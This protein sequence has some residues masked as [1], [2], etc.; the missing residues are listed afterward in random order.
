[1]A[2]QLTDIVIV[3]IYLL[4]LIGIGIIASRKIKNCEDFICA[5]HSLGFWLFTILMIGTVCSGMS[6]LGV[7]GFGYLSGW[8]GIWE[9]FFVPLAIS[10]CV[11][12]FGV[13]LQHIG[14]EKGYMTVQDYFA[15]RFQSPKTLRSLSAASGI[16]VSLIYLAG[17]YTAISIVLMWLFDIP[18]WMA[19]VIAVVIVTIYTTMGGLYAVAWTSM[20]QGLI[21]IIGVLIMAPL[22]IMSAGGLTHINEAMASIDP[23]L[24]MPYFP[25]PPYAAYAFCTPE[26][27]FSFSILLMV[28]LAC[29]PHVINN[30]LAV[31][32]SRY[33]KW[34]PLIG[35]LVYTVI[36]LLIKFAGFAG[37]TL[38]NEGLLTLPDVKNAQDFIFVYAVQH[39]T[40]SVFL[41]GIFAVI[42]L[43]AVMSTTDRLMLTVGSMFGWDIYR[44]VLKPEAKD[45]QV[46]RISQITTVIAAVVTLLFALNPPAILA[47]LIWMGIG[48]MLSTF[49][50]PL[51]AGLYWR[52]ATR[53]GAIASMAAGLIGSGVFGYYYQYIAKL[54]M[55]FS[56]YALI[57]SLL[58]MIVVSLMTKKT[59]DVIL[60]ETMTGWYIQPK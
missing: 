18:H 28:G 16:L 26:F 43:A 33:F 29:A 19:L 31:K 40:Q 36:M 48:I 25:S 11:I 35:F 32:E 23:N 42:I 17:Q 30:V 27:L 37:R 51:L 5:G 7:S 57:V 2:A 9:Q 3:G 38:V 34:V 6:L 60:N 46:L 21:L 41:W 50:I 8:P 58:A 1:M 53:E 15:H 54:P 56:I 13:K 55:H 39:A 45:R 4:I 10:F 47:F 22:V 44:N 12:F 20:V 24:V 52:G 59:D 49:A 14:R